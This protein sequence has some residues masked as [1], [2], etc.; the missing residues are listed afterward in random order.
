M[1]GGKI[2]KMSGEFTKSFLA[3]GRAGEENEAN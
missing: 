1:D 2:D 3:R